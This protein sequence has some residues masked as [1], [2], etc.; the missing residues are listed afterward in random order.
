M[1]LL[2]RFQNNLAPSVSI[3]VSSGTFAATGIKIHFVVLHLARGL[4]VAHPCHTI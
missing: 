4:Q 1:I 2:T 3:Y